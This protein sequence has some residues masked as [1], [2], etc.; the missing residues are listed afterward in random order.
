MLEV[1]RSRHERRGGRP[2][3]LRVLRARV[4]LRRARLELEADE[5]LIAYDPGVMTRLDHVG[6]ARPDLGLGSVLVCD[7][8]PAGLSDAHVPDLTAVCAH[9]G[10][11]ALGPFPARL[12]R[13]AGSGG[14]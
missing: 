10:L 13:H 11:H 8:E 2:E 6:V 1:G 12:E 4:V 7:V 5:A 9:D 14:G 3:P